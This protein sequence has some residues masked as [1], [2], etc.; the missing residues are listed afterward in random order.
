MVVFNFYPKT[1]AEVRPAQ[2]V[3]MMNY[4]KP[5]FLVFANATNPEKADL[6]FSSSRNTPPKRLIGP[7][8]MDIVKL[9][10]SIMSVPKIPMDD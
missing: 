6:L 1:L 5:S 10:I 8:S 3:P 4:R 9:M 2:L 7:S